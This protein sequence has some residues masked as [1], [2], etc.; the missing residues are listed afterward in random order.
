MR[1]GTFKPLIILCVW[2][3]N[4]KNFVSS[5]LALKKNASVQNRCKGE[6][7]NV[8][9]ASEKGP[10]VGKERALNEIKNTAAESRGDIRKRRRKRAAFAGLQRQSPL[11]T[12][13][14]CLRVFSLHSHQNRAFSGASQFCPRILDAESAKRGGASLGGLP[15]PLN[16]LC[17]K[18]LRQNRCFLMSH[19]L[20]WPRL[21]ANRHPVRPVFNQVRRRR[22]LFSRLISKPKRRVRMYYS[23]DVNAAARYLSLIHI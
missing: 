7:V 17:A 9:Y 15:A 6:K 20:S 8:P 23:F 22:F 16:I 5:S 1:I 3:S 19:R 2:C 18:I 12:T 14:G 11:T 21:F 10:L 4:R 13:K